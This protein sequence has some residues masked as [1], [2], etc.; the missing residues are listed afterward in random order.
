LSESCLNYSTATIERVALPSW[1]NRNVAGMTLTSFLS[2]A[3]YEMVLAILPGFL[4]LIGVAAA[5]LGWIEGASD[6]ISS[7][8]KLGA[9]WYSDRIGHRKYVVVLGYLF[10]GTGLSLFTWA[11]AWPMLLLGRMISWFGK[12]IRGSLR[13]AMMAESVAPEVRGKA[14]GFHRAGDTLGAIVGPLVGV[15]LLQLIPHDTP[16]R[17]FRFVFL[18]SLVPGLLAPLAFL[19]IVRE[20]RRAATPGLRLWT[21]IRSLPRP[22]FRYLAGVGLFGMGDFSPTLLILAAATLLAPHYRA[23]RAAEVAALLYALRNTVYALVSFPVGMLAD[24]Y[25]K[26]KLLAGGYV[27]GAIT[28]FLMGQ[29]FLRGWHTVALLA[30][31]FVM[32]GLF[33]AAQDTLEGAIPPE[34]VPDAKKGGTAYGTLGAVN[35]FGDLIASATVG[36]VWTLVSPAAAFTTA[37]LLMLLGAR[38]VASAK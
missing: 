36:T 14:F 28:A 16:D 27:L 31:I 29:A 26:R 12:G 4:P 35:G 7:F 19:L 24:R 2:D 21:A 18:F 32:A 13:D 23:V 17:P 37:A 9:G 30:G 1:L 8:L 6:A 22:Y 34:Y 20:T 38:G 11:Y 15:A 5:A 3:C 33:A 10:T 25:V